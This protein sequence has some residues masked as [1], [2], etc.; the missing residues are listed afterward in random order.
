MRKIPRRPL[1]KVPPVK[2]DQLQENHD[3]KDIPAV[4]LPY[5]YEDKLALLKP[6]ADKNQDLVTRPFY[7]NND[8]KRPGS[9]F[10][11]NGVVDNQLLNEYILKPLMLADV[12]VANEITPG[13]ELDF[14]IRTSINAGQVRT[15]DNQAEM[16]HGIFD[17]MAV[18]IFAHIQEAVIIDIHGGPVRS[19]E[20]PPGEKSIQGPREGFIE[21]LDI[22]LALV[23]RRLR[24]PRLVVK[25]TVVGRRTRTPVAVLYID[26]IADQDLVEEVNHRLDQIDTDMILDATTLIQYIEDNP[27]SPFPQIWLSERP[28]KVI[29]ELME[30]RIAVMVDGSPTVFFMPTLFV[31]F[32][33]ASEDYYERTYAG[34]FLRFLR[35]LAFFLA[36]SLPA[37]YIA[38][39]SFDPELLPTNLVISLGQS[40]KEVPFPVFIEILIQIFIIELIIEAGLRLPGQVGQT[41]GVVAGIIMGQASISAKLASPAV[42][43]IIAIATICTFTLPSGRLVQSIRILRLPL[44]IITAIFGLYG[45]SLGWVFILA[46]LASLESLGIPY[47]APF[48][49]LHPA[50]LNDSFYRIWLW[51]MDQRPFSIPTQQKRRQGIT[52]YKEGE[53]E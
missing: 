7:L 50:D 14:I 8:E 38:L 40:R 10:F 53:D 1:K 6:Y 11:I 22:N 48:A 43:I 33:Q 21:I 24:N 36:V 42:I 46:H 29:A 9:A 5:S 20:E 41:A 39:A 2:A 35:Y 4:P 27:F 12:P 18:I 49:P 45:F 44:M 34:S 47:F 25:R 26:D 3:T 13:R 51:K 30:G 16:I 17:G 32:F 52:R 15:T 31:E 19:P 23:R 28:D 37:L